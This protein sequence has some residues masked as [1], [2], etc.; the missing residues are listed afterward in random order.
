MGRYAV[1]L[2]FIK[3]LDNGEVSIENR[4][5]IVS[6]ANSEDE[7]FGKAYSKIQPMFKGYA[8][9]IKVVIEITNT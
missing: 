8:L 5:A 9:S 2:V 1:S 7:A 4:M 6:E 3:N